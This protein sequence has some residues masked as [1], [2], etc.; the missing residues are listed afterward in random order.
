MSTIEGKKYDDYY[1]V[2]CR[3]A[4]R[5]LPLCNRYFII[6]FSSGKFAERKM[7]NDPQSEETMA[8]K[9]KLNQR[10]RTETENKN[11]WRQK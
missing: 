4:E 5:F 6:I 10:T 3:C 8:R 7:R 2:L 9:K 11:A 1:F